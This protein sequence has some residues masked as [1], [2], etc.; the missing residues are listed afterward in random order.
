MAR[1]KTV[2]ENSPLYGEK[3][4]F[5]WKAAEQ[6]AIIHV[7]K[8]RKFLAVAIIVMSVWALLNSNFLFFI[9]LAL[10][11]VIMIVTTDVRPRIHEFKLT[12]TGIAVDDALYPYIDIQRFWVKQRTRNKKKVFVMRFA[13]PVRAALSVPVPLERAEEIRRAINE[14]VPQSPEETGLIDFLE[15]LFS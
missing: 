9:I 7:A 2:D 13:N 6:A 12:E 11:G 8:Y 3:I 14:Y 10:W 5:E 15:K 4:L 1:E